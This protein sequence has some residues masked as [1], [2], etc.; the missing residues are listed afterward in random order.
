MQFTVIPIIDKYKMLI[1]FFSIISK[2]TCA[3]NKTIHFLCCHISEVSCQLLQDNHYFH[4][5]HHYLQIILSPSLIHEQNKKTQMRWNILLAAP[6]IKK[7]QIRI[8]TLCF[9][10]T[11]FWLIFLS[12]HFYHFLWQLSGCYS[13]LL[14]K[15]LR[16]EIRINPKQNLNSHPSFLFDLSC[17]HRITMGELWWNATKI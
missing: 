10:L 16:V 17:L 9:L 8:F 15:Q 12:S 6:G 5:L 13:W 2:S 1:K 11:N 3:L 14:S 4:C 7:I